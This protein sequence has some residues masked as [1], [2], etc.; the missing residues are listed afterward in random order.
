[1][2]VSCFFFLSEKWT[3]SCIELYKSNLLKTRA[4][5]TEFVKQQ[6]QF[7][8]DCAQCTITSAKLIP[9]RSRLFTNS[10]NIK[11]AKTKEKHQ[12]P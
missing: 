6:F 1:M 9:L 8:W 10:S 11:L 5:K 4:S 12:F 3:F 2:N 7:Y